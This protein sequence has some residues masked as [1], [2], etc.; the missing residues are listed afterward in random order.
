MQTLGCCAGT[1]TVRGCCEAWR[2]WSSASNHKFRYPYVFLNN[3]PFS[4][5]FK[6]RC[7]AGLACQPCGNSLYQQESATV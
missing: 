6:S 7:G 4:D 1:R 2:E 5:E 3:G